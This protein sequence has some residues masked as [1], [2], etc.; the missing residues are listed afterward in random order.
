MADFKAA[1]PYILQYEGGWNNVTGDTGGETYQGI[2]RNNFPNWSGW[3]IIDAHKP[4][5]YNKVIADPVLDGM[6]NQFY[7]ANFWDK[8]LGDG[9]D[10][11]EVATYIYDWKVNAGNNAIKELQKILGV[12]VDGGF[13]TGTLQ[14][15]NEYQGNLLSDLHDAR[16]LYYNRIGVNGSA[17]FLNGWLSRANSLY[18]VLS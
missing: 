13:G 1:Q 17:K 16:V 10:S 6:V 11:Q 7:K 2:S 3:A 15:T 9:I 8:M 5:Q 12:T 4:I 18:N 14:A